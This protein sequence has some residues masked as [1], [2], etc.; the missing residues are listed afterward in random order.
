M[1][2]W[3]LEAYG[4]SYNLRELLTIKSDDVKG[5][6]LTYSAIVKG[7]PLPLPSLPESFKLLGK[8]LQGLGISIDVHKE[9]GS[10]ENFND[11]TSV[12]T[13]SELEQTIDTQET[14]TRTEQSSSYEEDQGW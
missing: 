5:R 1:E 6:N 8:Q 9:D 12:A 10:I 2:V 7:R 13:D 3:A 14:V 4:A 11:F